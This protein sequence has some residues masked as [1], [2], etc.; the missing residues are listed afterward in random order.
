MSKVMFRLLPLAAMLACAAPA[1]AGDFSALFDTGFTYTRVPSAPKQLLPALDTDQYTFKLAGLYTFDNPGF[2]VQLEGMDDFH[3]GTKFNLAHLWNAGGDF[4]F[5]DNKGTVGL[6]I[7]YFGVDAPALPL[8]PTKT[9]LESYGAFG[10][11][12]VFDNLTLQAKGGATTGSGVS[13]GDSVYGSGGFTFYDSPDVAL[14]MD[15]GYTSY[16]SAN[17]WVDIDTSIEYLPFNSVPVSLYLGYDF[18]N[19]SGLGYAK[20]STFFG[21]F[22]VHFGQGETLRDYQRT[23]PIEWTGNSTPG[24]NLKF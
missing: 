20:A 6:S 18:V 8:F 12:Y 4:F 7:S 13:R 10:E 14:H 15:V 19:I 11:W 24:A 23:G 5:R 2:A 16:K 1:S 9:S 22:K 17:N 3:Y 21:G